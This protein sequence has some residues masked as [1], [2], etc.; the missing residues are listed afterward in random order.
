MSETRK[1]HPGVKFLLDAGP[2]AIF[3]I[4]NARA[5]LIVATGALMAA[6]LVALA[7][8]YELTRKLAMAPLITAVF[9]MIFG[10]LT[11]VLKDE[12]FI[13]VKPTIIYALFAAILFAGHV[14]G[15][16]FLKTVFEA[17]MPPLEEE[18]WRK[19]GFRWACFF[20]AMAVLNEI[21]WRGLTTD[22]WVSF[23]VFGF[24]PLS[25]LFAAAQMPLINRYMLEEEAA[26]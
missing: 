10:G 26:E 3:F 11:V 20:A 2:L 24:M 17:A 14:M 25:F 21:A 9:V 16:P 8:T 23:K 15:K 6:V 12:T 22:Q 18:G 4:V 19:M 1:L 13:K 7:V 5:D